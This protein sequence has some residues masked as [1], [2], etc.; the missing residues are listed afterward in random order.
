MKQLK[1]LII[2]LAFTFLPTQGFA[3]NY[4]IQHP[5]KYCPKILLPSDVASGDIFGFCLA[6]KTAFKDYGFQIVDK[7][8]G[9]PVRAGNHSMRFELR[10]GDCNNPSPQSKKWN[11]CKGDRE[12]F[13]ISG[14][15]MFAGEQGW[16]AWSIFL[17]SDFVDIMNPALVDLGQ[18][19]LESS[20]DSDPCCP[21]L[22]KKT[23]N[24]FVVD[25]ELLNR[26]WVPLDSKETQAWNDFI[27]NYKWS[28]KDDGFIKLW[29]NNELVYEFNGPTITKNTEFVYFK[30]GIYRGG[31]SRYLNHKNITPAVETCFRNNGASD[32]LINVTKK[33][34]WSELLGLG[35][36]SATFKLYNQ[37][38]HLYKI[39]MPTHV[40]YYDEVRNG[41]TC[42]RLNLTD[43][44]CKELGQ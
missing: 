5:N 11:D 25:S 23:K 13:E 3:D 7:S 12:R 40:V 33:G 4:Q 41:K 20:K 39:K 42:K 9:H 43:V 37:C 27:V 29:L 1:L 16:S 26:A 36:E 28:K 44:N 19:H 2:L 24:G 32:E 22:F 34:E 31:L 35:S 6:D 38:K 8:N 15:D 30:F 21:M 18:F 17:P 10:D 14:R